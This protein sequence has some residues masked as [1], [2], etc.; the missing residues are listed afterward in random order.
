MTDAAVGEDGREIGRPA[1]A[2]QDG[3]H[4]ADR[5]AG[6]HHVMFSVPVAGV[7]RSATGPSVK[8]PGKRATLQDHGFSGRATRHLAVLRI[9]AALLPGGLSVSNRRKSRDCLGGVGG[10]QV[11]AAGQRRGAGTLP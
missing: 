11:V 6:D 2:V 7:L 9:P 3:L 5:R 1:V 4:V 8:V 10:I